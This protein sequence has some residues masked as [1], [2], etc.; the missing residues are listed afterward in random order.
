MLT[1]WTEL[2]SKLVPMK[3]FWLD[4]GI[5]LDVIACFLEEN[6]KLFTFGWKS[7]VNNFNFFPNQKQD[8]L[9]S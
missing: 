7:K 8:K 1:T 9:I 3:V 5:L 2:L 4:R 6:K